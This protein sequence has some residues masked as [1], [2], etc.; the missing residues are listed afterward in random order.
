MHRE[1]NDCIF[2]G[3]IDRFTAVGAP[4]ARPDDRHAVGTAG[5]RRDRGDRR[6]GSGRGRGT[7][8][9]SGVAVYVN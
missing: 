2:Q 1:T 5:V 9:E 3:A 4:E 8:K 6:R 7:G